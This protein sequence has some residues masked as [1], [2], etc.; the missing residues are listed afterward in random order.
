MPFKKFQAAV[1][2][3]VVEDRGEDKKSSGVQ[4]LVDFAF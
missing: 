1:Q 3:T 2:Q 4:D